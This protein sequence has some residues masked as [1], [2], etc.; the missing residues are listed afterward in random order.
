MEIHSEDEVTKHDIKHK[1]IIRDFSQTLHSV[2]KFEGSRYSLVFY[3]YLLPLPPDLI[4]E[5]FSI[6]QRLSKG[7]KNRDFF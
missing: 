6:R 1:P 7:G 5:Y 2:S 4:L 3:L